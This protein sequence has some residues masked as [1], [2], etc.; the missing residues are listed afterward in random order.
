MRLCLKVTLTG[1]RVWATVAHHPHTP[2]C[3]PR[4]HLFKHTSHICA[5]C[6]GAEVNRDSCFCGASLRLPW[7]KREG[8]L[9]S[10][11]YRSVVSSAMSIFYDGLGSCTHISFN[12]NFINSDSHHHSPGGIW[13]FTRLHCPG[14][15]LGQVACQ[16]SKSIFLSL[17]VLTCRTG[18][19]S[20]LP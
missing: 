5:T 2:P 10:H 7:G 12:I 8:E 20:L 11:D 3:P 13:G 6:L 18:M 1:I 4:P 19:A 17:H 14:Y 9:L 15:P 16:G